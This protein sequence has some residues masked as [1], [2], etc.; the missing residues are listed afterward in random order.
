MDVL[1]NVIIVILGISVVVLVLAATAYVVF[2]IGTIISDEISERKLFCDHSYVLKGQFE[3]LSG[4][5]FVSLECEKCK[6][7]VKLATPYKK[8]EVVE[9]NNK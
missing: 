9:K 5:H 1:R 8:I 6:N 2:L 4:K 7:K 3:G